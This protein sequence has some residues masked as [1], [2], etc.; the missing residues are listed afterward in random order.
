MKMSALDNK[1][2][3]AGLSEWLKRRNKPVP[4]PATPRKLL[5]KIAI[6]LSK[7]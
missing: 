1:I 7:K 6:I 2:I 3:V 5:N 4:R